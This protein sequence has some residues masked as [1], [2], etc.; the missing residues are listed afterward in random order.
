MMK[1]AKVWQQNN[2]STNNLVT[3]GSQT[4]DSLPPVYFLG[5]SVRRPIVRLVRVPSGSSPFFG[6][7]LDVCVFRVHL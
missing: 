5:Q 4:P 7:T 3:D 6:L 1:Q 2:A